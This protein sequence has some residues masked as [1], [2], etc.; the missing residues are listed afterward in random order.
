MGMEMHITWHRQVN[1]AS[2]FV[3]VA[4]RVAQ[5]ASSPFYQTVSRFHTSTLLNFEI[6][7]NNGLSV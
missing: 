6:S 3:V 7:Q 4:N 1:T 5:L 2:K